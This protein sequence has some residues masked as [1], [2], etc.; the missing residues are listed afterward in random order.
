M[1][2]CLQESA[3]ESW[4]ERLIGASPSPQTPILLPGCVE[5]RRKRSSINLATTMED[6]GDLSMKRVGRGIW[7]HTL[8][9]RWLSEES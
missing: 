1:P 3:W 7:Q 8:R 9:C 4:E 5:T 6:I 2:C